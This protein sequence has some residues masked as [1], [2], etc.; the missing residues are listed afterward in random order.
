M[1][2]SSEQGEP[3]SRPPAGEAGQ[4]GERGRLHPAPLKV[5][6]L[7]VHTIGSARRAS[8]EGG[9]DLPAGRQA[10]APIIEG[11]DHDKDKTH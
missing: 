10:Q 7:A 6:R 3:A 11:D 1:R 5:Q 9:G 2:P 4:A 8:S